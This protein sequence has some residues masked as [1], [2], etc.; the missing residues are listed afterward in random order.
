[1][2]RSASGWIRWPS[3]P[4]APEKIFLRGSLKSLKN[5]AGCHNECCDSLLFPPEQLII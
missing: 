2:L 5:S 4:G 1:M 3:E